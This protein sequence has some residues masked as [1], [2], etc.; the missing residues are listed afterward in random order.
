MIRGT[1]GKVLGV[2]CVCALGCTSAAAAQDERGIDPNQGLSLVEVNL[3]NKGAALR[4]Q[5][6]A[7]SYGVEFNDHYLRQ[8]PSG[9]VTATVFTDERGLTRLEAAGYE[10]GATI[11][12]P[13]TWKRRINQRRG[14]S[15]EGRGG[16]KA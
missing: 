3:P 1:L 4:L 10:V 7:G 11:E 13:A 9:S 16:R 6:E 5:L 14:A 8:N 12:S 2:A 15:R